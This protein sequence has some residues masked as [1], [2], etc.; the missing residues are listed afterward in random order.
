LGRAL[1][2][3]ASFEPLCVVSVRRAVVLVLK[4]K[5]EIVAR[6]GAELHSE[7]RVIAVPSVIRLVHFVRVPYR[8]RVPLSRRAVF[9]R[10]GHR[11][12]YCHR[13][14]ENIDHVV[15]RSRGGEHAWENVV[16]SCRACNARKE[17][18]TLAESGLRLR[19]NPVAP[20]ASLWLVATAG[21]YDPT[22]EQFLPGLE[23]VPA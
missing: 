9:A 22:W 23:A 21:A 12:Q 14:A 13:A 4:D 20:H 2:L 3:N 18:R 19:R 5:A 1:L 16:A 6:N 15:P 10:D 17:D 11:C 7:R 8:S